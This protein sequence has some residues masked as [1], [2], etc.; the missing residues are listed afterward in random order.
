MG[1]SAALGFLAGIV[2]YLL[3]RL[4]KLDGCS[5]SG[6]GDDGGHSCSTIC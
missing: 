3:L 4:R 1:S 6:G 2:V 5:S